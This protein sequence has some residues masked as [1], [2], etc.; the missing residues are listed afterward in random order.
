MPSVAHYGSTSVME[1]ETN[2][3]DLDMAS[4]VAAESAL[5]KLAETSATPRQ[6]EAIVEAMRLILIGQIEKAS[7]ELSK[8]G[9]SQEAIEQIFPIL[10]EGLKEDA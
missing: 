3:L 2:Y 7:S 9:F 4:K 10:L 1:H 6:R 8:G 5:P